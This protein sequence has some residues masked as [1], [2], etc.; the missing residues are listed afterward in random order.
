MNNNSKYRYERKFH[1]TSLDQYEIEHLVKQNT[2][3]FSEI[4]QLRSVNNIY[5]DS[6]DFINYSENVIGTSKRIK[7]RIRW[8]GNY[9]TKINKPVLEL[10]IKNGA[11]GKKL[12]TSINSILINENSFYKNIIKSLMI[13]KIPQDINNEIKCF[14]PVLMNRYKRKYFLS[15]DKKY[16]ITI[17][18]DQEFYRLNKTNNSLLYKSVEKSDIILEIKYRAEHDDL[19]QKITNQFPF[20]LTKSSKYVTGVEKLNFTTF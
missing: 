5:L 2:A 12:R 17:D 6:T 18:T 8:Y 9:A 3:S 15:A 20:R 14:L 10:K 7:A 13:S 11:L 16:R 19:I 1:I 4:F